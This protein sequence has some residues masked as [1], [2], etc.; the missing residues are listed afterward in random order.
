M[1][2]R[3]PRTGT[4]CGRHLDLPMQTNTTVTE[5]IPPTTCSARS[6]TNRHAQHHA[7][8]SKPS[9]NTATGAQHERHGRG[10]V[11]ADSPRS[12]PRQATPRPSWPNEKGR[13]PQSL[14]DGTVARPWPRSLYGPYH[15]AV[16]R[17][18][19]AVPAQRGA[20]PNQNQIP[21][22]KSLRFEGIDLPRFVGGHR[23]AAVTA[24]LTH[25]YNS[26]P[27]EGTV[28]RIKA[29]KR[30]MYGSAGFDLLRT[31]ILHPA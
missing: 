7:P 13:C 9:T 28:T 22:T 20:D 24:G 3:H 14:R 19:T 2:L 17:R 12:A 29:L 6:T 21:S 8:P 27:F 30:Q 11:A 10:F 23:P 18:R 31:R 1:P 15:A 16:T 4:S 5:G 25:P 26:G